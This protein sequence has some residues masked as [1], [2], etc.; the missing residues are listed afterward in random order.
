MT[1]KNEVATKN[2]QLP[3]SE[4]FLDEVAEVGGLGYSERGSDSLIPI[5][6]ILQDNSGE[7]KKKHERHIEGVEAGDLIIRSLGRVYKGEGE[8]SI[9]FQ[10]CGFQ[11]MWVEWSGEPGEGAVVDQ[12]VFDELIVNDGVPPRFE[13]MSLD[14]QNPDRLTWAHRESGTRLVETRYHYGHIIDGA[15]IIPCVI[16]MAGTNHTVSRQWTAQMKQF[17]IP[18]RDQKMPSFFRAYSIETL[19]NSKGNQSWYKYKITD[20]GPISDEPILRAGFDMMKSV[21]DE[22]ITVDVASD[23]EATS[24]KDDDLPV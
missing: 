16:P 12:H 1:K 8:S 4:A 5:L 20:R 9:L 17:K 3:V 2:D 10:P 15:D 7:V 13:E 6:S 19:F 24:E 11:H 14:P 22:K 23:N 18:G 21:M